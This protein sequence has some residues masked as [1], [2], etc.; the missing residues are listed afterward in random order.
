[1][2]SG[3]G[4]DIFAKVRGL[5]TDM[6]AKLEEAGQADA[7]HKAYCDKEMTE[8]KQ[9]KIDK[10][11]EVD[12]LSTKIQLKSSASAKLKEEVATIQK[13]L[14][15]LAST[16]AEMDS[17]R[18]EEKAIFKQNKA[19]T[20]RGLQGVKLALE[21][22]H[23]YYAKSDSAKHDTADGTSSGVI[24]LLEV[25]ESDF[26]KSLAEMIAVEDAAEAQYYRESKTNEV[27]K[28]MK[29][30]VVKYKTKEF[31][32]LDKDVSEHK[33]DRDGAQTELDAVLDYLERLDAMCIA[34]PESYADRAARREAEITGL[35]NALAILDSE[36][37]LL[38]KS[39]TMRYLRGVHSH[40]K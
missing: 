31:T 25:V 5:I 23:E 3:S 29:E 27:T 36:T 24:A 9:K 10:T 20:E 1:L 2:A 11:A 15:E 7:D 16:Q 18:A 14:A 22:L 37:A 34:K 40:S 26:S 32:G 30:Q 33:S 8:A 39:S 17:L 28:K 12:H 13:E 35:K 38:Q 21:V 19:D 6:I 4:E